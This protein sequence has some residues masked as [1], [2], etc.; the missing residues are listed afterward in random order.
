[1]SKAKILKCHRLDVKKW[2]SLV[3]ARDGFLVLA[4]DGFLMLARDG[5]SKGI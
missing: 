3:L 1:M 5:M 4:R 2:E